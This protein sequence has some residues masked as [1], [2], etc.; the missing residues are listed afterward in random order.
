VE[1]ETGHSWLPGTSV[2][3]IAIIMPIICDIRKPLEDLKIGISNGFS[4]PEI[5]RLV[6]RHSGI[7]V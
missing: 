4:L 3:K 7:G 1:R 6:A 2:E 5:V